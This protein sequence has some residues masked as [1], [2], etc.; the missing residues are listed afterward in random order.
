MSEAIYDS[1]GV[2][3]SKDLVQIGGTSYAVSNINS[4]ATKYVPDKQ[5][6]Q[7]A[8]CGFLLLLV[9]VLSVPGGLIMMVGDR[10]SGLGAVALGVGLAVVGGS[11]VKGQSAKGQWALEFQMSSGAVLALT[12]SERDHIDR[13]RS[14]LESA[15][16]LR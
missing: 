14:A 1:G 9:G 5:A 4:V 2:R 11:M 6:E 13:V 7:N 8:G 12:S 16:A 10:G 3:V 15:M